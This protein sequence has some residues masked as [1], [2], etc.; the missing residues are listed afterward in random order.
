VNHRFLGEIVPFIRKAGYS[1]LMLDFRAH[2]LSEGKFTSIGLFEWEDI[3]AVIGEAEKLGLLVATMPLVAYGRSM[4]AAALIN[5]ADKLPRIKAFILESSFAELRRAAAKDVERIAF[6]PDNPL[7]D[8]VFWLARL[9]TGI[10][11]DENKPDRKIGNIVGKQLLLIH[12]ELDRRATR[13]EHDLLVQAA[14]NPRELFFPKA[15]HVQAF[16]SDPE[17]FE[18]EFLKFLA[19]SGMGRK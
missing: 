10:P 1:V 18:T 8:V 16:Q 7:I 3:E 12:D 2:G 4:G 13:S 14:K 6:V 9:R 17:L 5:G 15:G 11:Y 19:S